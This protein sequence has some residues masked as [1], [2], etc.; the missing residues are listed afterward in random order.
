[1]T[2]FPGSCGWN[3]TQAMI[4]QETILSE[5]PEYECR[6]QVREKSP[7]EFLSGRF[8]RIE[9]VKC[10]SLNCQ[11]ASGSLRYEVFIQSG[12]GAALV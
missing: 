6:V 8:E 9:N 4:D 1:M 2:L 11:K 3:A 7:L 12:N 5:P 10:P